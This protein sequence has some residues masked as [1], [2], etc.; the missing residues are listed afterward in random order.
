MHL[1]DQ[2]VTWDPFPSSRRHD[3][4]ADRHSAHRAVAF[5]AVGLGLAGLAVALVIW[6]SAVFAGLASYHKL[7]HH[8]RTTHLGLGVIAAVAGIVANQV[9]ARYKAAVGRRIQSATLL[10]D[11]RHSWLDALSSAA[12]SASPSSPP[13]GAGV[14]PSPGLSSPASSSTSGGK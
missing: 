4:T 2:Q 3:D 10:G 8:G 9:V 5:S 6:A 14:T 1:L 11:A 13:G 7:T 12:A